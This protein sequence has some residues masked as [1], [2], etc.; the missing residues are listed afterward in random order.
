MK[1]LFNKYT[2]I[3]SMGYAKEKQLLNCQKKKKKKLLDSRYLYSNW[4]KCRCTTLTWNNSCVR[5]RNGSSLRVEYFTSNAIFSNASLKQ[6]YWD[7]S[8][9]G[10]MCV[11]S[12]IRVKNPYMYKITVLGVFCYLLAEIHSKTN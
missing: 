4:Y 2:K 11:Q 7:F 6:S 9:F 5:G 3:H 1:R 10:P 8:Y 12:E